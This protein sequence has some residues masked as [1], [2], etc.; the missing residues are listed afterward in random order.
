MYSTHGKD[1]NA[2][3]I[4]QKPKGRVNFEGMVKFKIYFR[5]IR[6]AGSDWNELAEERFQL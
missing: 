1:V 5:D 2:W 6:C 4:E 3:E